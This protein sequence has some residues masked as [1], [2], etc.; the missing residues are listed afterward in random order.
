MINSVETRFYVSFDEPS[1]AIPGLLDGTQRCVATSP[2]AKPVG[3]ITELAIVVGIQDLSDD[4]L[5][6]LVRPGRQS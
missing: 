2:R 3:M 5:E 6:E 4:L 1:A